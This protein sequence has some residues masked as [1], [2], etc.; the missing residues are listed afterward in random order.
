MVSFLL[1]DITSDYIERIRRIQEFYPVTHR[2]VTAA[3][4]DGAINACLS[5]SLPVRKDRAQPSRRT[6]AAGLIAP[7]LTEEVL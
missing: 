4:K 5:S 6:G 2:C 3:A 1:Y 7:V